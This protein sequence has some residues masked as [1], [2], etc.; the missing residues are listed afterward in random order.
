MTTAQMEI[1]ENILNNPFSEIKTDAFVE[2]TKETM[3]SFEASDL[4]YLYPEGATEPFTFLGY[5]A[6][7]A[8][9]K[10]ENDSIKGVRL[11]L[12]VRDIDLFYKKVGE[13]YGKM[14]GCLLGQQYVESHGFEY[15]K[16]NSK[17]SDYDYSKL[18]KPDPAD[19]KNYKNLRSVTW[20]QSGKNVR[21]SDMQISNQKN[22]AIMTSI[23]IYE[24]KVW[25]QEAEV[26]DSFFE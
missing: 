14:I 3:V 23:D 2:I 26:S 12:E 4:D 17:R 9:F 5:K 22:L 19:Y 13:N 8:G 6:L 18:P 15:L 10:V 7:K 1:S 20:S 24:V 16:K 21:W 11:V 25:F